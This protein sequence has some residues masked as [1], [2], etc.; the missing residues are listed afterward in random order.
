MAV[1]EI[2]SN[3]IRARIKALRDHG[4]GLLE[5][6]LIVNRKPAFVWAVVSED[7]K[8]IADRAG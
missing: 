7:P 3:E 5:I 2:E 1:D 6:A 4:H 8:G